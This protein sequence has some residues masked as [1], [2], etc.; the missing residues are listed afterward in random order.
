[1]SDLSRWTNGWWITQNESR[2]YDLRP[3]TL[4]AWWCYTTRRPVSQIVITRPVLECGL[5]KDAE[6]GSRNVA[7]VLEIGKE[8]EISQYSMTLFRRAAAGLPD[9]LICQHKPSYLPWMRLISFTDIL[10][11]SPA[12]G[13]ASL[14]PYS[15]VLLTQAATVRNIGI[16]G[17]PSTRS[18]W[19]F[20]LRYRLDSGRCQ[21]AQLFASVPVILSVVQAIVSKGSTT[22]QERTSHKWNDDPRIQQRCQTV[23]LVENGCCES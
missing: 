19:S 20:I 17:R 21:V 1:M 18:I 4:R 8:G 10:A 12:G 14:R 9:S 11:E 3:C 23:W 13:N 5:W 2:G 22:V 6:M 16:K 7:V 15:R